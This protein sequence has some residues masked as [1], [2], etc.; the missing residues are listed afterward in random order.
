MRQEILA[1][2]AELVDN[3]YPQVARWKEQTGGKVIGCFPMHV[4]EELVHAAGLLPI[5]L[6]GS[7]EPIT[8]ANRYVQPFVCALVRSNLDLALRGG[9]DFL[10]GVVFPDICDSIQC[11]SDIWRRHRPS[12]FHYHLVVPARLSTPSGRA[13]LLSQ[14]ADLKR[15]LEDFTGHAITPEALRRSI[16]IY[17]ENRQ[18]LTRLYDLRRQ[19]PGLFRTR[20]VSNI[21]AAS[22]FL[23]KEEH[24]RLLR[25][26]LE[27]WAQELPQ[28]NGRARLVLSGHLCDEPRG[29]LLDLVDDVGGMV[30]DD[31]LYVGGRYFSSQAEEGVAPLEALAQRYIQD[32]P[33]PTK[34]NPANDWGD[35]LLGMVKRSRAQGVISLIMKFCEPHGFDYVYLKDRLAQAGVPHIMLE[36]DHEG[37]PLGQIST[38]LQAF[39]ETI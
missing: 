10:D 4:P 19:N 15:A 6:L 21:V 9:L 28:R 2:W 23:P 1:R 18:L 38:R 22:M 34:H 30:V 32:I 24:S 7:S 26:L 25:P 16:A 36:T 11:I 17:R 5:I 13:Y 27:E 31:D 20:E 37:I 14:F 3:P 39:V 33:C 35:Y 8:A 29:S 12:P